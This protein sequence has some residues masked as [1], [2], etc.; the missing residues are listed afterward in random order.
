MRKEGKL[1]T[2]TAEI[3]SRSQKPNR[4]DNIEY[5]FKRKN[6]SVTKP[7]RRATNVVWQKTQYPAPIEK[8]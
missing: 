8:K 6:D 3:F 2:L 1:N 5:L 7:H 4:R